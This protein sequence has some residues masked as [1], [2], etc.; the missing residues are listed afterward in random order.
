[1]RFLLYITALALLFPAPVFAG[2]VN[3]D[4]QDAKVS[5][6]L[7]LQIGQGLKQDNVPVDIKA[8]S[9]AIEDVLAGKDPRLTTE[10]MQHALTAF[11]KQQMEAHHAA[12]VENRKKGEAF[13]VENGKKDGVTQTDSGI[14]YRVLDAGSGKRKPGPTDSV[15]VHYK[16]TLINGEEFDSSYSRGEPATFPL[17]R[18]IQGWQQIVPMMVEGAKWEVVIPSDLAYGELGSPGGIGPNET[19]VFEIELIKI[20]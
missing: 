4:S 12:G 8:F 2:K 6:A 7:G 1:M 9:Q 3:L 14:Q 5:Y 17:N 19:L 20:N 18:V 11:Q 10:E 15:T 16:G 13:M